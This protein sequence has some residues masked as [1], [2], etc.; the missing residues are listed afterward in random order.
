MSVG[1]LFVFMCIRVCVCVCLCVSV[2]VCVFVSV[3]VC[4]HACIR[5]VVC[6][7]CLCKCVYVCA[8]VVHMCVLERGSLALKVTLSSS[9]IR[10]P[11]LSKPIDA[12]DRRPS[13]SL[14]RMSL[15]MRLTDEEEG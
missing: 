4:V 10:A 7:L 12:F 14:P 15:S 13:L 2:C 3:C 9:T 8:C 1:L 11:A 5:E 6:V